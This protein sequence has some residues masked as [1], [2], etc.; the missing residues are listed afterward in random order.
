MR[1]PAHRC[2]SYTL[3]MFETILMPNAPAAFATLKVLLEFIFHAKNRKCRHADIFP[4]E[5][6]GNPR[7]DVSYGG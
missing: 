2:R 4:S 1:A 6:N 7:S 5:A 3:N